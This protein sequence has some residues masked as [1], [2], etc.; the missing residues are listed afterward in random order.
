MLI[1][2][3]SKPSI[4]SIFIGKF[5]EDGSDRGFRNIGYEQ[6][7][8]GELRKRKHIIILCLLFVMFAIPKC[9]THI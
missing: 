7:D 6:C 8:A 1:A 5:Y 2:D 4:S 3:V 9:L